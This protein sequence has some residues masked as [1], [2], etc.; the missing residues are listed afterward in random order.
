MYGKD[1]SNR[2]SYRVVRRFMRS[3]NASFPASSI[4][5]KLPKWRLDRTSVSNGHT[6]Q[7]GTTA[8]KASFSQTMRLPSSLRSQIFAKQAA[9]AVRPEITKRSQFLRVF[10]RQSLV[11]PDLTMRMRITGAHHLTA[12]FKDLNGI[13]PVSGAEFEILV[14]PCVDH[15]RISGT[16]MRATVRL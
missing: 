3:A 12:I 2:L 5:S 1:V 13:D 11:R 15:R 10:V 4:W 8:T 7:K 9:R 16:L 14:S 6:A